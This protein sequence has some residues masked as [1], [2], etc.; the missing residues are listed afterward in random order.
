MRV[1]SARTLEDLQLVSEGEDLEVKRRARV[2]ERTE[3]AEAA[4]PLRLQCD[5]VDGVEGPRRRRMLADRR[6]LSPLI[7]ALSR[8]RLFQ[9]LV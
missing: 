3:C 2:E 1:R 9:T 7:P 8:L 4:R 5:A 6:R